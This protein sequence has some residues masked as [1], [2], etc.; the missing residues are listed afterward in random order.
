[1]RAELVDE[2]DSSWEIEEARFRVYIFMGAGNA[3]DAIDLMHATV[4]Q[5]LEEARILAE[6]DRHLW[7]LALVHDASDQGR[8][9]V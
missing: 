8:G 6:G 9:L 1:M 2:R 7:S 3:V 4:E 5:A